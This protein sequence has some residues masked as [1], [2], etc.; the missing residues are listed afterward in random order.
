MISDDDFVGNGL[1][2]TVTVLLLLPTAFVFACSLAHSTTASLSVFLCPSFM[3]IYCLPQRC[4][5]KSFHIN[6]TLLHII[7]KIT[8]MFPASMTLSSYFHLLMIVTNITNWNRDDV[9]G[10]VWLYIY[11][12][13]LD[14]ICIFFHASAFFSLCCFCIIIV[15]HFF[16]SNQRHRHTFSRTTLGGNFSKQIYFIQIHTLRAECPFMCK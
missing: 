14:Q 6:F 11:I 10:G 2:A 8:W 9:R 5:A 16:L 15:G 1:G 13:C 12:C 3:R 7:H 4:S